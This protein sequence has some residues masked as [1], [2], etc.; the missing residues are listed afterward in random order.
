[1]SFSGVARILV[2]VSTARVDFSRRF[3]TSE[4]RLG[5]LATVLAPRRSV[6]EAPTRPPTR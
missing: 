5:P 3:A 4:L 2:P 1:M 6:G